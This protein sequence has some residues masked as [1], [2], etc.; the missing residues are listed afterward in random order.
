MGAFDWLTQG[1]AKAGDWLRQNVANPVS[2]GLGWVNQ[3][4]VQPVAGALKNLPGIGTVAQAAG[5]A[6]NAV[7][8]LSEMAAGKRK[9]NVGEALGNVQQAADS[10]REIYGAMKKRK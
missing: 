9:F 5:Q 10:G 3:N 2:R 1:I 8:N 7:Q 6:G 4:V